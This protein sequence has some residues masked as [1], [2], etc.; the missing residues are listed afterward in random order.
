MN[1]VAGTALVSGL[2]CPSPVSAVGAAGLSPACQAA[3]N[4]VSSA[5]GSAASQVTGFGVDSILNALGGWVT[6]GASW[7]LSQIGAVITGTTS[8]DLGASWFT[9]HYETMMALAAVVIVPLLL[10]GIMQA[11]YRQ[12]G[13]MLV[14]SVLVNV[15]L[16][17][18]LT[19]VAVKLVELGV[20]V[21]DVMSEAVSQGSGS[22]VESFLTSMATGL[23]GAGGVPAFVLFI[24]GLLVVLGALMLWVD[25]VI[26]AAAV[27]VAV[28]FLPLALASVAWPAISHWCRRLVDALVA[29]ILGKFVIVAVLSLAAGALGGAA[30]GPVGGAAGSGAEGGTGAASGGFSAV[31]GGA[32]LLLLAAFAP[33]ALFRLVPF[34]EAGAI[35]HLEAV[36]H[37]TRQTAM[38]PV[39]DL[40]TSAMRA[41]LGG[42]EMGSGAGIATRSLTAAARSL[43]PGGAVGSAS[44]GSGAAGSESEEESAA[45]G[46]G[47]ELADDE[48]GGSRPSPEPS[49][50][51]LTGFGTMESP[52]QNIPAWP[53]H[54]EATAAA[55]RWNEDPTD[56]EG[57]M[58]GGSADSLPSPASSAAGAAIGDGRG[59]TAAFSYELTPLRR[60]TGALQREALGRDE[61]GVR[62]IAGSR[63]PPGTLP[64]DPPPELP[65]PGTPGL[66]DSLNMRPPDLIPPPDPEVEDGF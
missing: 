28:L 42:A 19:V 61:L 64:P 1:V 11:V 16:A 9:A 56:D 59:P 52:A 65:A 3:G 41:T 46:T 23:S 2:S 24:C 22:N 40:A 38:A 63:L 48:S 26:R 60:Q 10:F 58:E 44:A 50:A 20:S 8:I 5:V 30:G 49:F 33:W 54:P 14:R 47:E 31:L 51:E 12:S 18:L 62:L 32:A 29:L 34:L 35:G 57:G 53:V 15:P 36:S 25:L 17:I 37:R 21:T 39:R 45:T 27:Y 4:V 55:R 13:S 6:D 7:L 66:L 43:K